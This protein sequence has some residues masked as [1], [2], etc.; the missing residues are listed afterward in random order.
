M[1][2]NSLE[3]T[4]SNEESSSNGESITVKTSSE[5]PASGPVLND[6]TPPTT[7][8]S[9]PDPAPS[10]SS[11]PTSTAPSTPEP[12]SAPTNETTPTSSTPESTP[13]DT[14]PPTPIAAIPPKKGGKKLLWIVLLLVLLVAGAATWY[15]LAGKSSN[16]PTTSSS[17]TPTK[18][19]KVYKVGVVSVADA[20]FGDSIT[21][22]KQK[23]AELGYVE[24]KNIT[25]DIQKPTAVTGNQAIIKKFVDAK[26]DLI[27]ASPTEASVEAK[28]GTKGTNIPVVSMNS[29]IEGSNL[30]DS[31]EKPGGNVSGVRYPAPEA[32]TKR[33]EVLHEIAPKVTKILLPTLKD[34]P[35]VPG[36][37]AAVEPKAKTLG[38]T[39]IEK[40][41]STP[42]EVTTY[43]A[44]LPAANPGFDGVLLIAE[45]LAID[46]TMYQPIYDFAATHKLPVAGA[47]LSNDDSG[48]ILSIVSDNKAA[49]QL[50]APIAVKLLTGTAPGT[51]PFATSPTD[52]LINLKAA[53]RVGLTPDAGLLSTAQKIVR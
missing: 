8:T 14:P 11:E 4:N 25:Y 3:P 42:A 43:L 29:S 20:Y 36:Q 16:K 9:E 6:V 13:T 17:T 28:E 19:S 37:L 48:P 53:S 46:P 21:S 50:A 39:L 22:F 26:D 51:I 5:Q 18:A 2:N 33:L 24:G 32:A 7:A 35:N 31:V 1:D 38:L 45:P 44:S 15:L 10:L 40:S 49:G 34:Y 23:M 41:F 52:L 47:T 12:S 30:I 27:V